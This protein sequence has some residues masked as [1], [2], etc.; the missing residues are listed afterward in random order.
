MTIDYCVKFISVTSI[1]AVS[2]DFIRS[3]YS[4]SEERN[5][6]LMLMLSNPSSTGITLKVDTKDLTATGMCSLEVL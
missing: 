2:V 1:T 6:V 4:I 3:S 5:L